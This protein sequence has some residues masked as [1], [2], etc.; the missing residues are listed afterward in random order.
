MAGTVTIITFVDPGKVTGY[1]VFMVPKDKTEDP[2]LL[3]W[4][5]IPREKIFHLRKILQQHHCNYVVY[6]RWT[7][8]REAI[9]T[10]QP[11]Y[12]G[13]VIGALRLWKDFK[14]HD[15]TI[16]PVEPAARN[17]AT[18]GKLGWLGLGV[19]GKHAKDALQHA[20]AWLIKAG[21]YKKQLIAYAQ[22]KMQEEN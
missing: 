18:P 1:A 15:R 11:A 8:R 19:T 13:E 20:V 16:E 12:A 6:E 4:G 7:Q 10:G 2:I 9:D 22:Y 14:P 21:R 17:I 5:E 3:D